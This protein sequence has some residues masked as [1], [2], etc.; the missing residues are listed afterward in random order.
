MSKPLFITLLLAAMLLMVGACT[1]SRHDREVAERRAAQEGGTHFLREA[2]INPDSMIIEGQ[3]VLPD[4]ENWEDVHNRW[5]TIDQITNLGLDQ[6]CEADTSMQPITIMGVYPI[7]KTLTAVVYHQYFGDSAPLVIVTYDG[8]GIPI[9]CLNLGTCGGVNT[10]YCDNGNVGVETAHLTFAERR[11]TVDRELQQT[12]AQNQVLWTASNTD[13]YEIDNRGYMLHQEATSA[14]DEMDPASH[15]N[16]N[17]EVLGWYSIQDE[18]AIDAIDALLKTGVNPDEGLDMVLYLRLLRSPWT[19]AQWLFRHQDS[20]LVPLLS[21]TCKSTFDN[22]T[23]LANAL[24]T[25]RDSA[26]HH[27]M[28]QVLKKNK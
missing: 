12:T 23:D 16:R 24:E 13:S 7:D 4:D 3:F 2:G 20:P 21:R 11:L 18:Q 22:E 17:L 19:T 26:Q 27:F 14:L 28:Q 1:G 10:R 25:V 5:L 6:L 9:D 8:D 15:N